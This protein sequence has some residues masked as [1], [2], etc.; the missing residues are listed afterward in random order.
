MTEKKPTVLSSLDLWVAYSASL[1]MIFISLFLSCEMLIRSL[2]SELGLSRAKF[3][4]TLRNCKEETIRSWVCHWRL[5]GWNSD[6]ACV[7]VGFLMQDQKEFQ[8]ENNLRENC[9]VKIK[10]QEEKSEDAKE[11]EC[12]GVEFMARVLCAR[13]EVTYR[14][15]AWKRWGEE[16]LCCWSL[17]S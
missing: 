7:C 12:W 11:D 8:G 1:L 5:P 4:Q 6:L 13:T 14:E 16:F 3:I 2:A 10:K 17:N 15:E 9:S